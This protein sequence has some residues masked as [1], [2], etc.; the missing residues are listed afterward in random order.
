MGIVNNLLKLQ[1]AS[2]CGAFAALRIYFYCQSLQN[3]LLSP[4]SVD[5]W[6]AK[7]LFGDKSI[8]SFDGIVSLVILALARK[9]LQ[10]MGDDVES[11]TN[12][13]ENNRQKFITTPSAGKATEKFPPK[14]LIQFIKINCYDWLGA[15]SLLSPCFL[16]QPKPIS[17]FFTIPCSFHYETSFVLCTKLHIK[18]TWMWHGSLMSRRAITAASFSFR[19]KLPSNIVRPP[20]ALSACR[21]IYSRTRR[22]LVSFD[23]QRL[24]QLSLSNARQSYIFLLESN[25]R[26]SG[27]VLCECERELIKS[28]Q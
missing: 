4:R 15:C 17:T 7:M 21:N 18:H 27:H 12:N 8:K 22:G 9:Q 5:D 1:A 13:D 23:I 16:W 26:V 28:R 10:T 2:F 14:R 19:W 25:C 20:G 3:N 11:R 6:P 24:E